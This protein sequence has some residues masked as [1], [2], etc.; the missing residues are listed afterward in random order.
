MIDGELVPS[1][2]E[3]V[4]EL[5]NNKLKLICDEVNATE[6]PTLYL[7]NT[8]KINKTLNK[9]REFVGEPQKPFVDNFRKEVAK[10]K[11]YKGT[12]K[13]DKPYHY[14]NLTQYFLSSFDTVV[15]EDGLEADDVM[16]ILQQKY[17]DEGKPDETVICSRDKDLW[18]C[19]G[20]HYSWEVGKQAAKGPLFVTEL[21]WLTHLN[22]GEKDA[23]GKARPP[24]IF[25]C[26]DLFFYYQ[27]LVGD[28]IDNI[29]GIKGRGPDFAYKLLKDCTS[30]RQAYEFVAE[31][32]VKT[33]GDSWKEKFRE[34]ADLLYMI[35]R[36]DENGEKIKWK[37]PSKALI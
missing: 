33:W 26:G 23:K 17:L 1:S 6:E 18:Q 15:N 7:T 25:G 32:Y 14:K 29:G 19:P 35:R 9:K 30:T 28:T 22:E 21:G 12:R 2:W 3:F 37:P 4:E 24:K 10:E 31:V 34:Q 13:Q 36:L 20:W 11:E 27:L 16:C 8:H 5:V